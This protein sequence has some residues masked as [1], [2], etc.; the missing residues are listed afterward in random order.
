MHAC[1]QSIHRAEQPGVRF[2][3]PGFFPSSLTR[4]SV[5]IQHRSRF[6]YDE[7][8]SRNPPFR[9]FTYVEASLLR[10]GDGRRVYQYMERIFV[11]V[12]GIYSCLQQNS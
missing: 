6:L 2:K 10:D 4:P 8:I 12:G 11:E 3:L 9:G 5:V 1:M 7:H